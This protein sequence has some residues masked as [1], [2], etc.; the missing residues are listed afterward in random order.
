MKP[1]C[2]FEGEFH[3]LKFMLLDGK[4]LSLEENLARAEEL[5]LAKLDE[6]IGDLSEW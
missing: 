5:F 6:V 3:R 4:N 2:V 1:L